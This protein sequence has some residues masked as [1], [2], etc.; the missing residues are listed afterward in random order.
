MNLLTGKP[1][2]ISD[3]LS[4]LHPYNW[5]TFGGNE[6]IFSNLA[7]TSN[8]GTATGLID[9]PIKVLPTEAECE[10]G[11]QKLIKDWEAR[12]YKQ[13]R[14]AEYPSINDCV[15]AILDNKN[16]ELDALQAKRKTIKDKFPKPE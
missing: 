5:Y 10:A 15:H 13:K 4:E 2:H 16:G 3:F 1:D 11:L 14:L 9:N 8:Y 12:E 6:Q 7:L